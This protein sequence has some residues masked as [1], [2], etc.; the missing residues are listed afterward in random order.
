MGPR[1]SNLLAG[2]HRQN[3]I[4]AGIFQKSL[5][6]I[7]PPGYVFASAFGMDRIAIGR[8]M[9]A[10]P[11]TQVFTESPRI[12]KLDDVTPLPAENIVIQF[13]GEKFADG[14]HDL[15]IVCFQSKVASIKKAHFSLKASAPGGARLA[16]QAYSGAGGIDMAVCRR[17]TWSAW[18][19]KGSPGGRLPFAPASW[20]A[21]TSLP[22]AD[23]DGSGFAGAPHYSP[24]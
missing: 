11:Y 16:H 4:V 13:A 17:H 7:R 1:H 8:P 9:I 15:F 20:H 2:P 3:R 6:R 14:G 18:N 12:G 24:T 22:D 19:C 5:R 10:F 21:P 23:V